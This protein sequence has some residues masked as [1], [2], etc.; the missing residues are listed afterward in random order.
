MYA[1]TPFLKAYLEIFLVRRSGGRA[2]NNLTPVSSRFFPF[3]F[4]L[5]LLF[6]LSLLQ[7]REFVLGLYVNSVLIP[8]AELFSAP[9]LTILR[10]ADV[11][12]C[13]TLSYF[14]SVKRT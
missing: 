2:L 13:L 7:V 12:S 4:V 5:H 6:N 14:M 1:F 9:I 11:A 3:L 8:A 10:M